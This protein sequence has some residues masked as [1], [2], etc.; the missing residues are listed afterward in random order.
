LKSLID[1]QTDRALTE[2]GFAAWLIGFSER[3]GM[4]RE[5]A[6]IWVTFRFAKQSTER[7]GMFGDIFNSPSRMY[8]WILKQQRTDN[9]LVLAYARE[10]RESNS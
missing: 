3:T 8:S 10:E 5:R 4:S 1:C 7:H 9:A 6:A 2:I